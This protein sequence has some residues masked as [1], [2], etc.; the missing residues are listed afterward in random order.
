MVQLMQKEGMVIRNIN[1]FMQKELVDGYDDYK[2]GKGVMS[3]TIMHD[4]EFYIKGEIIMPNSRGNPHSHP[5]PTL[6]VMLSGHVAVKHGQALEHYSMASQGDLI[7]IPTHYP[8]CPENID[9]E[10][11]VKCLVM[12]NSPEDVINE[13]KITK[14]GGN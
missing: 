7:Y 10:R 13:F 2:V 14:I 5:F 1:S 8:H 9:S 12:R 11:A 6:I 4:K 3:T